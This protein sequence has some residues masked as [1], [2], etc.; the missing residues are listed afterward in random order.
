MISITLKTIPR[1]KTV[2]GQWQSIACI[3][4]TVVDKTVKSPE[5]LKITNIE[6]TV[7]VTIGFLVCLICLIL[8]YFYCNFNSISSI[9]GRNIGALLWTGTY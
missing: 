2:S 7:D 4:N 9:H 3:G 6:V 1:E 8:E 5:S